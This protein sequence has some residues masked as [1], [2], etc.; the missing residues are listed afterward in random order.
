[1]ASNQISI[2]VCICTYK[3]PTLLGRLLEKLI[4]Q[5]TEGLFSYS[6]VVIDNDINRSAESI[7]LNFK[8]KMNQRI[9]YYNE[10]RQNISFARNMA[11]LKSQG[12]FIAFIDDDEFPDST[13]LL[14]LYKT[15]CVSNADGVLGPVKP[16]FETQPPEWI[17]RS[18]ILERPSFETG[19][20]LKAGDT[21]TGN[22]L[23]AKSV[24]NEGISPFDPK[25]GRTGGEDGDFFRRMISKGCT[26]VWCNEASVYET[27]PP[28]RF[29]RTYFLKRAFL[30]GVSEARLSSVRKMDIFKSVLACSLYTVALPFLLVRQHLFMKYL[31][32]DC[33]HAGKILAMCGIE[34]IKERDF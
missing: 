15:I 5:I 23:I 22:L 28:E 9:D 29:K 12:D 18:N 4:E 34:V 19:T 13:W 14:N 30:R 21:R 11:V 32:K 2:S 25:F 8:T 33:D 16:H 7:Y 27:I 1:M 6:I 17:L 26:F 31:I 10:P 20:V 3:R 24:F